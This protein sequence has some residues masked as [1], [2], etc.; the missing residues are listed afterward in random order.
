MRDKL[1]VLALFRFSM[2]WISLLLTESLAF[3]IGK[4]FEGCRRGYGRLVARGRDVEKIGIGD[5]GGP[6]LS[7][8]AMRDKPV[9]ADIAPPDSAPDETAAIVNPPSSSLLGP[10]SVGR[11]QTK[12]PVAQEGRYP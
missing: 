8:S 1:D 7:H 6:A 5:H 10:R 2:L 11:V 9:A 4:L 12:A 3:Q